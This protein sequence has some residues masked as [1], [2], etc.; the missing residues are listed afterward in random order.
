MPRTCRPVQRVPS[1]SAPKFPRQFVQS[2]ASGIDLRAGL[3]CSAN[4]KMEKPL[5]R[6]P[7][8]TEV[9]RLAAF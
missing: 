3:R 2:H 6:T 4:P 5:A 8:L 9:E 1:P 7:P